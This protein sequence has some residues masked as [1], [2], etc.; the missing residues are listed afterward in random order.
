L[1]E[2]YAE[3]VSE[4]EEA[5]AESQ[6]RASGSASASGGEAGGD[7]KARSLG[8]LGDS[9]GT[10]GLALGSGAMGDAGSQASQAGPGSLK[11]TAPVIPVA[12]E[13]RVAVFGSNLG[14]AVNDRKDIEHKS[15]PANVLD[16]VQFLINNVSPSNVQQKAQEVKEVLEPAY[17]GWLGQYLVVK[18]ISTQPNFHS[19]YLTF[20]ENLGDYG[21]GLVEAI[22]ASV[23]ENVGKL[24][25]SPKITTSTSERS[26]LKNLGSWLG[27]ITLARNRPILQIMLDCKELLYQGYECGKLIAVTPFVA[28]ILEGAKNS[29]V[30]R[31][32]NPWVMGLLSVFRSLYDVDD[33][34][35]NIK[36]EVEVL[37][38]NLGVKLEDIPPRTE[39]LAKRIPPVKEKNPDFNMKSSM[40]SA[41]AGAR[42]GSSA[43]TSPEAKAGQGSLVST[44]SIGDVSAQF[45]SAT[46]LGQGTPSA[47]LDQQT[48][49]PNLAAYVTIK[50]SILQLLLQP[51]AG[52]L[53]TTLNNAA[54]KQF[55]PVAVDR[56]IREIIQPVVERSVNIACITTKE[57]VTK[58]FAMESDENKMRKA[59]QLMVANLAGSLALVTCREPLRTSV[60]TILRQLLANAAGGLEKL[61]EAEQGILE[62]VVAICATDNLE[63]GCML[64]EKAATEKAVRDMD[65]TLAPGLNARRKHREQTGQPFYDMSI[66][67]NGSQRY[68]GA[69][70]EPLRPKPGGLRTDQL[71]VYEAFQRL[72]RQQGSTS[73]FGN[74][75]LVASSRAAG[76]QGADAMPSKSGR[77]LNVEALTTVA[78]KLDTAV[79]S[80]LSAAGPRAPEVT[81]SMLPPEHEVRQL[82]EPSN[83]C[84]QVLRRLQSKRKKRFLGSPRVSSSAY[85]S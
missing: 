58:D 16:R 1:K 40:V 6:S 51:Q 5:M 84:C 71:R 46:G 49:I 13:K 19:L 4:I 37:C 8:L 29:A 11:L 15:P 78:T 61:S 77:Q 54:L 28:K 80:L 45:A 64:I 34:K 23:Y 36:F 76:A 44:S 42:S 81:L 39:D 79:T 7:A 41:P 2:G 85:T 47:S 12:E 3:L 33:L 52:S 14:R 53:S 59:A 63:L 43:L 75:G 21:K 69:L 30:F 67:G 74:D 17:F 27:Q 82:L 38:K 55:V 48:V 50:Q 26:L 60:S 9:E 68:P 56:A 24:L 73:A 20:L 66:F 72:P 62:Q 65:D 70:P 35:M 32:P 18:R 31:P 25:V 10:N 57:I 22:L 83:K